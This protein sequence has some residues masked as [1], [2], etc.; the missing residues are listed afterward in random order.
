MLTTRTRYSQLRDYELLPN[1]RMVGILFLHEVLLNRHFQ[2]TPTR[3]TYLTTYSRDSFFKI[4]C[5][6]S[7]KSQYT[8][9]KIS[10][11]IIFETKK[12]NRKFNSVYF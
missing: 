6:K 5:F 1:T 2:E 11:E 3:L 8:L 7:R 9:K 12:E 4:D 10:R